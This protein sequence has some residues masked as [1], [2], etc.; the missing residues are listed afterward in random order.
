MTKQVTLSHKSLVMKNYNGITIKYAV[1]D[2]HKTVPVDARSNWCS[3]L[4]LAGL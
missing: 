4:I 3:F 1:S 2:V